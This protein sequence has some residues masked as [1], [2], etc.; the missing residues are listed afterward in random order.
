MGESD[1]QSS[2]EGEA[3]S[4]LKKVLEHLDSGKFTR[5]VQ[6]KCVPRTVDYID[7]NEV[8]YIINWWDENNRTEKNINVEWLRVWSRPRFKERDLPPTG[9]LNEKTEENKNS[10]VDADLPSIC[11]IDIQLTKKIIKNS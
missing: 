6:P 3:S 4:S 2:R 9:K 5:N 11:E 1:C 10:K 8:P 7:D